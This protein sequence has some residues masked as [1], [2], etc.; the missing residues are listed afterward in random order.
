MYYLFSIVNFMRIF[1]SFIKMLDE[2]EGKIRKKNNNRHEL[3][4]WPPKG[5]KKQ[6]KVDLILGFGHTP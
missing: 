5:W 2:L 6:S 1:Q 4:F 3:L